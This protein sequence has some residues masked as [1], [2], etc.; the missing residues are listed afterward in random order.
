VSTTLV[1]FLAAAVPP[2]PSPALRVRASAVVAPC[3]QAAVRAWPS[4]RVEVEAAAPAE[5][6]P[7]DVIVASA[8]ELTR[9]LEG[10]AAQIGSDVDV[11][12]VPWVVQVRAGGPA[13]VRR[14]AD[15]A[16]S[17]AEVAIPDSPAAYEARRWAAGPGGGRF[18]AAQGR[19][20]REAPVALV[21]L[22]LAGDG[23]R[24]PV[25]VPPMIVRAAVAA[26]PARPADARALVAFLASPEGQKAFAECRVA[27]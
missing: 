11:A 26:D 13:G 14:A 18:R 22:T 5:P 16:A 6:G 1:L 25:D 15:V 9:A 20:L 10:S 2:G 27:P 4:G 23:E 7:A 3:V 21:P 12:R 17:G 8:V 19:A 24:L